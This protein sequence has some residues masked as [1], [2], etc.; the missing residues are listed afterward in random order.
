[1]HPRIALYRVERQLANV[2]PE[3]EKIEQQWKN[4]R[5]LTQKLK[6]FQKQQQYPNKLVIIKGLTEILPTHTWL[7]QLRLSQKNLEISGESQSAAELI[8]LLE[9]S[10]WL[11]HTEF[12]SPIITNAQKT[13]TF[14]IKSEVKSLESGF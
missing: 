13:E 10:G 1:L 12:A 5:E 11:I 8:P 7:Y 4:V 14:K 9:Q 3:T 6:E 2:A